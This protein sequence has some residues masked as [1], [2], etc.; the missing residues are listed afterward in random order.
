MGP[1]L[2][3]SGSYP[4][5]PYG[6]QAASRTRFREAVANGL[7]CCRN[8]AVDLLCIDVCRKTKPA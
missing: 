8:S 2:K 5:G 3:R 1:G 4:L 7:I 6:A